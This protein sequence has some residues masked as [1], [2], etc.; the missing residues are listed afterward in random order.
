[1]ENCTAPTYAMPSCFQESFLLKS[2]VLTNEQDGERHFFIQN[3]SQVFL[4][5]RGR[6]YFYK[7]R[8]GSQRILESCSNINNFAAIAS[9][10][11]PSSL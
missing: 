1:M 4:L 8:Y 5:P 7:E 11:A 3:Y 9:N 6:G 10:T 2:T